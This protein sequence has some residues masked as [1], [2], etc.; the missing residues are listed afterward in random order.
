MKAEDFRKLYDYHF[1]L[2]RKIWDR[3]ID[4]L[5][6]EQFKQKMDYSTGSIRNQTVHILN[7][8]DRWFSGLRGQ[9]IPGFINPVHLPSKERVRAKWD[10]VEANM[11][12]YLDT[13]RD[14][15]I[16]QPF[17]MGM[18]VWQVLF[19]VLNHGTDHRAQ[20]LA[21]LNQLGVETF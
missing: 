4:G 17:E 5:T 8:D 16:H 11:K 7:I 2:N 15:D 10:E 19:H 13:L 20:L 18:E 9:E 6:K 1:A 14:E 3:C 12:E 21:M